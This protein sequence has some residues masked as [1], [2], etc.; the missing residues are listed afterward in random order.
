MG[1]FQNA[2]FLT[3][4]AIKAQFPESTLPEIVLAGR[5]N[6]GKS[7]LINALCQQKALAYVGKRPGKTRYLNF[8]EVKHQV[9]FV[10]V[11]GFGYAQRSQGELISY[12]KLMEDYFSSREQIAAVMMVIDARHG[13]SVDD[14]DMLEFVEEEGYPLLIVAT[15]SDKLTFSEKLKFKK[16]FEQAYSHPMVLFSGLDKSGVEE[17]EVWIKKFIKT[18]AMS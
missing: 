15:K 12:G 6:V 1:L 18:Q 9:M 10:D 11:P 14:E 3:T 4:A 13:L 17:V 2:S 16:D 8:Y 7:S 5:S